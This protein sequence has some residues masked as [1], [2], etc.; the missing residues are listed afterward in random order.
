VTEQRQGEFGR[1]RVRLGEQRQMQRHQTVVELG[2][3]VEVALLPGV[4]Q[5]PAQPRRDVRGNRDAAVPALRQERHDRRV[6]AR[7]QAEV[8]VD[9]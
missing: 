6:L 2:D 4:M 7:Q 9:R 5:I 3:P 8:A 1:L